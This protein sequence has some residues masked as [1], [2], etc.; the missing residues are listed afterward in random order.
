[1]N[2]KCLAINPV[3]A[4]ELACGERENIYMKQYTYYRG[5][6]AILSKISYGGNGTMPGYINCLATL[7]DIRQFRDNLYV[8]Q[9]KDVDIIQPVK[10]GVSSETLFDI[11]FEPHIMPTY[12]NIEDQINWESKFYWPYIKG[13]R[14]HYDD[15]W[16]IPEPSNYI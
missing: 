6:V 5:R 8:Y 10:I 13:A 9:F 15:S 16:Y 7:T 12:D 1:M 14:K 2:I 11:D 3:Q 4:M